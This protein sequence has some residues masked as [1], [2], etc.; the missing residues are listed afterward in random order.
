[1]NESLPVVIVEAKSSSKATL[2][3]S[4]IADLTQLMLPETME[5]SGGAPGPP[6]K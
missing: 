3:L 5:P 1:M 2:V 4:F 6:H